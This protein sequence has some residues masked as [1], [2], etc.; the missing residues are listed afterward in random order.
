[1]AFTSGVLSRVIG[2]MERL[3]MGRKA[4]KWIRRDWFPGHDL[5]AAARVLGTMRFSQQIEPQLLEGPF[6]RNVIVIAPHPDDE[7]IGPGGT[8]LRMARTGKNVTVL[9]VTSGRL[10]QRTVREKEARACCEMYGF[11]P[12]FAGEVAGAIPPGN[13]GNA[14]AMLVAEKAPGAI[15]LPFLLD[16]HDDHRRVNEALLHGLASVYQSGGPEIWAYQVYTPL[17]GN[18]IVDITDLV[19]SKAKAIRCYASQMQGRDWAHFALGLNAFNC[20]FLPGCRDAR[21]AESFFVV[22]LSEYLDL[23]RQYFG[24]ESVCHEAA[25]AARQ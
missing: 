16:D 19:E 6:S 18:V 4:Y 22:P 25:D 7:M 24:S 9:F 3:A 23:C 20:R 12:R 10:D 5:A 17:P 8:L 11:E 13:V 1:M 15:F 2:R 21:Y 14:I